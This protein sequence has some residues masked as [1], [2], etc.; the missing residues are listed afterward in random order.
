MGA[1]SPSLG[2]GRDGSVPGAPRAHFAAVALAS[3]WTRARPAAQPIVR[4][5]RL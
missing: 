4:R 1:V 2:A 3:H 5:R